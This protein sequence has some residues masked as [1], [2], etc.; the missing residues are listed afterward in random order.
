[1]RELDSLFI[2]LLAA[3]RRKAPR[4]ICLN[5]SCLDN[6]SQ[7]GYS[8]RHGRSVSGGRSLS[9]ETTGGDGLSH[10]SSQIH[11]SKGYR[12]TSRQ[13]FRIHWAGLAGYL[14]LLAGGI[15]VFFLV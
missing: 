7:N 9:R 6:D 3:P 15:G 1:M 5:N 10:S 14:A 11:D 4:S 12:N 13:T 8:V 2:I